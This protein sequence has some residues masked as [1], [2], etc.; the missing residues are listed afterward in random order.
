MASAC[1][2]RKSISLS[3]RHF[4]E[5]SFANKTLV[6]LRLLNYYNIVI[7]IFYFLKD[8]C[9]GFEPAWIPNYKL[10]FIVRKVPDTCLTQKQTLQTD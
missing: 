3:L 4:C 5:Q 10:K 2:I 9:N 8:H 6:E 1:K 7:I